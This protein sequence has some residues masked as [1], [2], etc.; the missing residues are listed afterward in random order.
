MATP[1]LRYRARDT[2]L[3]ETVN[4]LLRSE[5]P[6]YGNHLLIITRKTAWSNKEF[7]VTPEREFYSC[8]VVNGLSSNYTADLPFDESA[9]L[10]N[11]HEAAW[12]GLA[13]DAWHEGHK[14]ALHYVAR[15]FCPWHVRTAS[16]SLTTSD[17]ERYMESGG[18]RQLVRFNCHAVPTHF[19]ITGTGY[20]FDAYLR[21]WNPS[22]VACGFNQRIG[23]GWYDYEDARASTA[24]SATK[25]L[26]WGK[27][28]ASFPFSGNAN[29]AFYAFLDQMEAPNHIFS[30]SPNSCDF[31]GFANEG[32]KDETSCY[33]LRYDPWNIHH[34]SAT[35]ASVQQEIK[36][37]IY[38][39]GT[40][41]SPSTFSSSPYY[42]D[43]KITG[44][45]LDN[46]KKC[47][48]DNGGAWMMIGFRPFA[49]CASGYTTT[50][51]KYVTLTAYF[52]RVDLVLRITGIKMTS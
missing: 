36:T 5:D 9:T 37:A 31:Y 43:H 28:T 17:A 39:Q 18:T 52:S 15:G 22:A 38:A 19:G 11:D 12:N 33:V 47:I 26:N 24:E 4:P 8:A 25:P 45:Q 2:A 50:I 27:A 10:C 14:P 6:T 20:S 34:Y 13:A 49:F 21:F 40:H 3:S 46:L 1:H 23:S 44:T 16:S 7:I 29:R 30:A 42:A 32:K 48:R 41:G 51:N 35:P